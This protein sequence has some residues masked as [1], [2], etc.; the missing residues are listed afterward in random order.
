MLPK[1]HILLGLFFS[2]ILF[3]FFKVSL[4]YCIIVFL[5]SVLIDFDHYLLYAKRKKDGDL[6]KCYEWN[7]MLPS[8]H[9]KI[10]HIFHTME[11]L[12]FILLLSLFHQIF[13]FV[14]IGLLFHSILDII[15]LIINS[16]LYIREFSLIRYLLTKDKSKYL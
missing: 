10:V 12:I 16:A 3:L 4:F 14:F 13:L 5:A 9:K 7:L 1:W 11:F 6:K 15:E 8:K 2:V